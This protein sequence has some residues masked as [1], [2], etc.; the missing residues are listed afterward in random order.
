MTISGAIALAA[1]IALLTLCCVVPA[2]VRFFIVAAAMLAI[3][4]SLLVRLLR[5][6]RWE[7]NGY[8]IDWH[9]SPVG[10]AVVLI[11][12]AIC[13][14]IIIWGVATGSRHA[15]PERNTPHRLKM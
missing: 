6:G 14:A 11:G 9:K 1:T 13:C 3:L 10:M 12:I 5:Q 8:S 15:A 7:A 2:D 4:L